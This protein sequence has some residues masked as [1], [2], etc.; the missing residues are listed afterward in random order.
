M[1]VF[2]TASVDFGGYAEAGQV[3][4]EAGEG[5][6]IGHALSMRTLQRSGT[7]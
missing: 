2:E 6:E 3:L 4:G 7:L 5:G 1:L